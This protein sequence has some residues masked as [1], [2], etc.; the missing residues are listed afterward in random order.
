MSSMWCIL[1]DSDSTAFSLLGDNLINMFLNFLSKK[2]RK[3]QRSKIEKNT[4][5][6]AF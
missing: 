3:L 2:I 6:S 4:E 5:F 1:N